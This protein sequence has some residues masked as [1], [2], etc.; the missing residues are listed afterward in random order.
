EAIDRHDDGL[1]EG[2]NVKSRRQVGEMMFDGMKDAAQCIA[3]K[4]LGEE[5]RNMLAAPSILDALEDEM[6]VR[7][8]SQNVCDLPRAVGAAVLVHRDV[9]DVAKPKLGFAQAIGNRLA[10]KARPM[11][12]P[13]KPLLFC[14]GNEDSVSH[15]GGRS[16]AVKG[17][18][19]ED[20]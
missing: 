11:L 9:V 19:A 2:G 14:S 1:L 3:G 5:L 12:D 15:E 8:V 16:I 13:P 17:V 6:R 20:D 4:R 10:G 7:G 18:K